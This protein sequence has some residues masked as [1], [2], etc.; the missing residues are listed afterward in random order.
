ML[1]RV[2]VAGICGTGLRHWKVEDPSVECHIMEH[3]LASEVV[4]VGSDV[5]N[6]KP[7]DRVVIETVIGDGVC[8]HCNIQ[9]YN[10]CQHLYD[11]R[12]QFVS[13]AYAEYVAGPSDKYYKL[14]D[15]VSFEEA[16]LVDTLSV[17]L[18]RYRQDPARATCSS[19]RRGHLRFWSASWPA[20]SSCVRATIASARPAIDLARRF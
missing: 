2:H 9:R 1:A 3:E 5:F 4:E 15:H 8:P 11:V 19:I 12:T 20:R 16:A 7:G 10:I 6:V 14:P 13:R 18:H 17:C